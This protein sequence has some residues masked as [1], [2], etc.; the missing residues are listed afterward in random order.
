MFRDII[1]TLIVVWVVY[2]LVDIFRGAGVPK[3]KYAYGQDQSRTT[4]SNAYQNNSMPKRDVKSAVN[5]SAD[6]E[7]EYIDFEEVK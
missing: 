1:W 6:K 5:K 4:S 3:K 7:G 2:K